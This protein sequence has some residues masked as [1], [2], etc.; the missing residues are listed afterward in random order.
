[1]VLEDNNGTKRRADPVT[2][3]VDALTRGSVLEPDTV[4]AVAKAFD[5]ARAIL[6]KE[7]AATLYA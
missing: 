3:D 6:P 2:S 1:L 7:I 5:D 4:Y